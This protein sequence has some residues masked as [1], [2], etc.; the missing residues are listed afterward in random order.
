[1]PERTVNDAEPQQSE[2][3]APKQ[4]GETDAAALRAGVLDREP[5][6]EQQREERVELA[7]H[8]HLA[9][10]LQDAVAA[11]VERDLLCARQVVPAGE[12]GDVRNE[13]SEQ[14]EAAQ[15]LGALV[16]R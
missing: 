5:E 2:L 9:Q 14:R 7:A 13:D 12:A 16:L 10:E 4:R 15:D 11:R 6:A 8:K 1:V 3:M